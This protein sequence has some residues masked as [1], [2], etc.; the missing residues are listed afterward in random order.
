MKT[1]L[2]LILVICT[3]QLTYAQTTKGTIV[4]DS[5]YSE[6]LENNFDENPTREVGVYLP[7]NYDK[8]T[9]KYP[10]IYFLHGFYGDHNMLEPMKEIL[11]FAI[12]TKRI[13]PFILVIPNQKPPTRGVF[14]PILA[15]LEIGRT[16]PYKIW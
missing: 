6:N 12:E 5:I 14:T 8:G 2:K 16:L 4:I 1:F 9:Q 10:V 7:P 3:L 15:F 11:D 13:R